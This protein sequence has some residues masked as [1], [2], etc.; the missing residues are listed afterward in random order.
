MSSPTP[1]VAGKWFLG[2]LTLG[3]S[4]ILLTAFIGDPGMNLRIRCVDALARPVAGVHLEVH[5][6]ASGSG[7]PEGVV[8][9]A[10][11]DDD[12]TLTKYGIASLSTDC[13][14][15]VVGNPRIALQVADA[16]REERLFIS[17]CVELE[18]I[19][20]VER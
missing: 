20:V 15:Q 8:A 14:I 17:S 18:G 5:C 6:S 1:K 9:L 13:R 2:T 3:A 4:L 16:C 11:T 19:L 7:R 12:G 10:A